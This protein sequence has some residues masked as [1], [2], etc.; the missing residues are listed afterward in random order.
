LKAHTDYL[1]S[2]IR[3]ITPLASKTFVAPAQRSATGVLPVAPYVVIY[4]AEGT[5]TQER[6]TGP[7]STQHPSF[8]LHIVGSSYDNASTVAALIKTK[9]VVNGVGVQAVVA[10]ER[11]RNM[12]Y[13]SPQ[14]IQVDYDLTPPLVFATAEI[15]WDSEPTL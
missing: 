7:R 1:L 10:G 9:F 3:S 13:S 5:D 11:C 2:Q 12:R 8:T 4:P 14:P 6:V 15:M